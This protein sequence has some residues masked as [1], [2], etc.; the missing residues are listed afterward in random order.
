MLAIASAEQWGILVAQSYECRT[1]GCSVATG[2][3]HAS[4]TER[5]VPR[6]QTGPATRAPSPGTCFPVSPDPSTVCPQAWPSGLSL[7]LHVV[8]RSRDPSSSQ[9]LLTRLSPSRPVLAALALLPAASDGL[10]QAVGRAAPSYPSCP[11]P[12][13]QEPLAP[14]T[15]ASRLDWPLQAT[16]SLCPSA[17]G[18]TRLWDTAPAAASSPPGPSAPNTSLGVCSGPSRPA[19]PGC[20]WP[21]HTPPRPPPSVAGAARLRCGIGLAES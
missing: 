18:Q 3:W 4:D 20:R 8:C 1:L 17:P 16:A 10:S 6:T 9:G 12:L 2:P 19:A 5:A 15:D 21:G 7:S 11:N 14:L 13:Q